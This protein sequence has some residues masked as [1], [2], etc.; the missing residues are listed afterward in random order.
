VLSLLICELGKV[1]FLP[2]H[3]L[4]SGLHLQSHRVM[5]S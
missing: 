2:H 4:L 3:C 1:Q 5:T